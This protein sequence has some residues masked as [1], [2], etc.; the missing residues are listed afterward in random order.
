MPLIVLLVQQERDLSKIIPNSVYP[1]NVFFN[2]PSDL[3]SLNPR[4]VGGQEAPRHSFPYQVALFLPVAGGTSFCGGSII[5]N[6]WVLTAAHCVDNL[7][8]RVEVI[9]GAHNVREVES[10]QVV[11]HSSQ[12]I[13]HPGWDS[14]TLVNDVALILL[15]APVAF[16]SNISP[17]RLPS[18]SQLN[19]NFA[20]S[21]AT[22]SGWGLPS[23]SATAI[24]PVLRFINQPVITNLI[25]NLRF[26]GSIQ[27]SHICTSGE[28]GRSTC[29]GDSGGPLVIT[30]A[31][32]SRTQI[33]V[34]SFGLALGCEIGWPAAYA[35]LTSYAQW[36]SDNTGI[37]I[38]N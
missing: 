28:G 15:T 18:H 10:S 34:V 22:V 27:S 1:E 23:D 25:C 17:I 38:R 32:G 4:I 30:E 13:I 12:V 37:P 33:G 24:S 14:R 35:R 36:I 9:L 29:S 8:D 11:R 7:V 2:K 16:N 21:P 31:D 3:P 5:G 26:L 6:Q 20:N 19:N